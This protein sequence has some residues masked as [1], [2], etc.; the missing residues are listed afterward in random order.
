MY[1]WAPVYGRGAVL[2]GI[3]L[4]PLLA[5]YRTLLPIAGAMLGLLL[6]LLTP[7]LNTLLIP[8]VGMG[9][10]HRFWQVLPWPV[11]VAAGCCVLARL[12]GRWAWPVA[13]GG[14]ALSTTCEATSSSGANRP[15]SWSWPRSWSRSSASP[16]RSA[17]R[18]CAARC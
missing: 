17:P 13:S 12:L 9:Q 5:R 8:V 11:A 15:A 4:S 16:G 10:F 6:L 14:G 3:V 7:G 18:S 2:A 1:P